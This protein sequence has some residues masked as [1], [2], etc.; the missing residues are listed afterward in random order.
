MHTPCGDGG[1][2]FHSF[3]IH[4]CDIIVIPRFIKV[5]TSVVRKNR[6]N[7]GDDLI[8]KKEGEGVN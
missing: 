3:T 1:R 7:P 2:G 4:A 8:I 5:L 6:G